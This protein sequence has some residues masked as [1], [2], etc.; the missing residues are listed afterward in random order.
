MGKD[1]INKNFNDAYKSLNQ[2]QKK[3][4]DTIEGPILVNAGPGTGK[5]QILA[6]RI[7]NILL[8]ADVLPNNIL[9]LTYTDN[10]AVEMRKRLLSIIGSAAYNIQIHTFHSF[11]N[12]VIQDNVTYFGK[13][14]LEP[15]SELEEIELFN[16]IIDTIPNNSALKRFSGDVYYEKRRL[17]GLFALMKKEAWQPEHLLH[18]I[19]S[20]ITELPTKEGFYYKRK[21]KQFNAGDAK[22]GAINAEI[23]RMEILKEAVKLFPVYNKMMN[24]NSRYNFDDMILWVLQ[25]FNENNNLLL[26]YQERF[27]YILVDEFQ[28]TSRS[29][30]L[31]LQHLISYWDVPNVFVVGDADQSIFSFQD[32]NVQNIESFINQYK[33]HIVEIDLTTNYR[34]TQNILNTAYSLIKNNALRITKTLQPLEASDENRQKEDIVPTILEF[35]TPAHEAIYIAKQIEELIKNKNVNGK[36][37]AVIYRK[38]DIANE[39][40]NILQQ[41]NI[42]I[43]TKK[44]VNILQLP[45]INNIIKIL[46]WIDKENYL[47]YSGDDILFKILHS[48]FWNLKS[49]DIAK[50]SVAVNNAN[51]ASKADKF[52]LRRWLNEMETKT[53]DLFN[54]QKDELKSVIN[55][56]ESLLKESNNCT[57]QQLFEKVIQT[58]GILSFIMQ[59]NEKPWLMQ[60]L[61]S[62]FNL[63]KEETKRNSDLTLSDLVKYLALMEKHNIS[64]T[65]QKVINNTNGV[66]FI[67]AHSSKGSEFEYVFVI[68]CTE[69]VWEK[70]GGNN[71]VYKLP[72]NLVH[73]NSIATNNEESRRLFYVAITRAKTHLQLSYFKYDVKDKAQVESSFIAEI[74]N[75]SNIT[76]K[77]TEVS[78]DDFVAYTL[79]QFSESA[80]PEIE[81]INNEY[82]D[83]ILQNYTLSVTHLNNYLSCP[84]KFYYQNLI[85]VPSA[86]NASMTFGTA[87]H[88]ALETLFKNMIG[89]NNQ[90]PSVQEFVD[91]FI[92]SMKKNKEAFTAEEYKLKTDYGYKILPAYYNYHINN[93][94]KI[95]KIEATFK[96][97]LVQSIPINGKLDKL[98]FNGYN[99]NVVDYKTG[100]F[101][102]AKEKLI[103]PCDKEPNG[104]DY[105]RQAVFYKILIDNDK[106]NNWQVKSTQFEFVEPEKEKYEIERIDIKEEDVTTVKQQ[107]IEVW[108]KIQAKEFNK[109]CGKPTC[110]WC[111]FVKTNEL[112]VAL[113]TLIE[114]DET[115]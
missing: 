101:A 60:V 31:L 67:T 8:N 96:N 55:A 65:V 30:N 72:D 98:E 43:N 78:E 10:G 99:V 44:K 33:Q 54:Q 79:L 13:L 18:C 36:D 40:A 97:I 105:W 115:L 22:I 94:Q 66:N 88:Y 53:A 47:P 16:K 58:C 73:N 38:H 15:I 109:G 93:W 24:E 20:Y 46:Q 28:D 39:I 17:Q 92:Y 42:P 110:E 104:G 6:T 75:N 49:L 35:N 81:L 74:C 41:K 83:K 87:V 61:T 62:L 106:T 26:N 71:K 11:C 91:Y 82:L 56:L 59:S 48:N 12:E 21:Y 111:N 86:K 4:V 34:S 7:G 5:T 95:V 9:C 90:F 68:G 45:F 57:V 50:I 27:L 69:N 70:G 3:A 25:A 29:Q 77:P 2:E 107:I 102:N 52:S 114:E 23:E 37:I 76:I 32:A 80:I 89:N 51:K 14:N 103:A 63:I 112:A 84:I 19:D 64:P 1:T 108:N 85:K 100:K 113:H